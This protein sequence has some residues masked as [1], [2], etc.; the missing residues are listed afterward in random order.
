MRDAH[1]DSAGLAGRTC[2]NR[3]RIR[4]V[5]AVYDEFKKDFFPGENVHVFFPD[6]EQF[7]GQIREKAKSV[8]ELLFK[9]CPVTYIDFD[10]FPMIRGPDGTIQRPAFSRYF[11]RAGLVALKRYRGG[12]SALGKAFYRGGFEKTMNRREAALILETSERGATKDMIRKKHRQMM[13]LNHPHRGGSPY[14]TTKI[15]E[16]KEMMEK[17]S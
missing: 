2:G 10:R 11:G 9:M 17:G 8:I 13:L 1:R 15:N 16:A 7:F 12:T 3:D 4:P 5:N 14:L 6:G